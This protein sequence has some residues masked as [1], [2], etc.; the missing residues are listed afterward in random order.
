M[1]K[2]QDDDRLVLAGYQDF[3][4]GA[5]GIGQGDSY[6]ASFVDLLVCTLSNGVCDVVVDRSNVPYLLPGA[7]ALF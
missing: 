3:G 1:Y 5:E 6:S 7:R 2:R 4:D